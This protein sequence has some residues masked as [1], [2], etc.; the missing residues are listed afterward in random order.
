MVGEIVSRHALSKD[1]VE[2]VSERTGGVPLFVEEVTRLLL[3]RG[4]ADAVQ[5]IP[6][7]LQQSLAARLDRLGPARAIAQIGA[8]LGQGFD[9]A[10][11]RTVAETDEPSLHAS[12]DRLADSD[13][14]FVDGSPPQAKYRFKH[15]LVLDAAYESLLKGRRKA[16]HRRA[17]E[18]L[19][20][21]PKRAAGEPE[22]IAHHFTE[23][24]LDD[25][26]IEWWGRAGDQALRRSAFQEAIAHLGK[27]IEMADK[28]EVSR[29]RIEAGPEGE[30][31]PLETITENYARALMLGRG[32]SAPETSA[33]FARA[34]ENAD[35]SSPTMRFENAH[36][37]WIR[38]FI[39]GSLSSAQAIAEAF[40]RD[41]RNERLTPELCAGFH[42][43]GAT[44]L[45][46]GQF[47]KARSD[48][49]LSLRSSTDAA[50]REVRFRFAADP[51]AMA[52]IF[53]AIARWC[54]GDVQEA[55]ALSDMAVV[56]AE[57][58]NHPSTMATVRI[59][60]GQLNLLR[61]NVDAVRADADI[62]LALGREHGMPV[63]SAGGAAFLSWTQACAEQ[64][65]RDVTSFRDAVR[66]LAGAHIKV[67]APLFHG[68][69]AEQ[70]LKTGRIQDA[71][72]AVNE[73]LSLA[74]ED[75]RMSDDAFLHRLRGEIL[76]KLDG[77]AAAEDAFHTALAIAKEQGA[78]TYELF[79]A[80]A[81]ARLYLSTARPAD[82]YAVLAPALE[83]FSPT[84]EMPEIAE[85]EEL[86]A[87]LAA[88]EPVAAELRKR[89]TRS[90]LY[91]GYALAT[92]MTKGYGAEE[93]K[94][95]L[96]RA[97]SVSGA[98]RTPEYWTVVYGRINADMMRGDHR[99]ACA[100]VESFLAEA[101]AAG[102][103]GHAA[104]ARRMR[105]FLKIAPGDFAGARADLER[106]LADYDERRDESLRTVFPLDFRSNALRHLGLVSWFLGEFEE[107][108]RLTSEALQ[109]G[110]DS[111]QLESYGG[112]LMNRVLIG[113]LR[114]RA[115]DVLSAAEEI[116]AHADKHDSKFGRAIAATYAD[117]ARVR[118]GEP[119]AEA[120]R[121][122]LAAYADL[123]AKLQEALFSPLIAEV[124]L[125]VGGRDETL[126]A[127]ER[128]LALAAETGLGLSRP[129]LLRLRGDALAETDPA[130][131]AS[132]YRDA[133]SVAGAQGSRALALLAA[134]ALAKL[135]QSIGEAEE[136]HAILSDALEGFAPTPLFP[137]IAEAQA[138]L[139][140]LTSF[141]RYF[142]SSGTGGV[143]APS[144]R[145]RKPP[146]RPSH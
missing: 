37:E 111:G 40:V 102:L 133:L 76:L 124:E 137:A 65:A 18:V 67:Q 8:V 128:G 94:A 109:R 39:G 125:A 97:A 122:G 91:A 10:L 85:A 119:R 131:A 89:E 116:R 26:A 115:E 45:F 136:A 100:G 19:R 66:G 77:P 139:V 68:L 34:R 41:A 44:R 9:Y 138:L 92:M 123:R 13:L 52:Q 103:P 28:R 60:R 74:R 71:L 84:P 50:D 33:A 83:G 48:L 93:T 59:W 142:A 46:R 12:L 23:A 114:G 35:S 63:Y 108:E 20:D 57:A 81:L 7:T 86:L 51:Q 130:G 73:A 87:A 95:A 141:V 30:R 2:G 3:E 53:L 82:A 6:A 79:A 32:F 135:L 72:A 127:V 75:G 27:A 54:I 144:P 22:V 145:G 42:M 134:L 117:W 5:A 107:A 104:F 62:V 132:A 11:L 70:E 146:L 58:S 29:P 140:Q 36:A 113:A 17:A 61:R 118:L 90:K 105:G 96:A 78:R 55:V 15:A 47:L 121:A 38:H 112:A 101:E 31:K 16:L 64:S 24:G 14:L 4:V 25:L 120:F 1:V 56:T 98:T 126:A 49:E 106:A 69:L 43:L 110:K 143:T 99:A 129:W 80:L 21:E 88:S